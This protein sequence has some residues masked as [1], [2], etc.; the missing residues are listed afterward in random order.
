MYVIVAVGNV[1]QVIGLILLVPTY[2]CI[3]CI[4][5]SPLFTVPSL[6]VIVVDDI[7]PSWVDSHTTSAKTDFP[8]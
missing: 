3:Y 6:S 4:H 8:T 7:Q 1:L 5:K 2:V